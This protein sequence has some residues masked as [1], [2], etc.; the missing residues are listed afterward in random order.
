MA[1]TSECTS[2]TNWGGR[3]HAHG[4]RTRAGIAH[5]FMMGMLNF[6]LQRLMAQHD[7]PCC[8]Q[9]PHLADEI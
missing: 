6:N 5:M 8:R 7:N 3:G 4:L 9:G 1:D 2:S